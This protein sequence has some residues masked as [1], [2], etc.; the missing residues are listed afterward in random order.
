[1]MNVNDP[2]KGVKVLRTRTGKDFA[3]M[4]VIGKAFMHPDNH[5]PFPHIE[6]MMQLVP[7]NVRTRI[8]DVHAEATS[9]KQ[10]LGQHLSGRIS[11]VY[12]T[13]SH[14]PTADERILDGKT[15]FI[16]DIG[17][18]GPY[19]SVIGIRKDAAIKRLMTGEKQNFQPA[20][21]NRWLCA[22][23]ADIDEDSGHCLKI[24]RLRLES[25]EKDE[26]Q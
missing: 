17:M 26:E 6:R 13:H 15:G 14:V 2:A 9:E 19:D 25:Q 4:N 22:V 12:G 7:Q 3:V 20:T 21:G 11:L 23:I 8:L 24:T 1:M 18:T 16:T 10:G 5:S